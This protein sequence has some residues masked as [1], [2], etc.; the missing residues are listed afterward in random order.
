MNVCLMARFNRY[1]TCFVFVLFFFTSSGAAREAP[2][3]AVVPRPVLPEHGGA[4]AVPLVPIGLHLA[5]AAGRAVRHVALRLAVPA[6]WRRRGG[7]REHLRVG[8]THAVQ[9]RGVG[10]QHPLLP[11]P[12]G[13][14]PGGSA[15]AHLERAVRAQ[16]GAVRHAGARGAAAGRRRPARR[17]HVGRASGGLHGPHPGLSGAGGEAQDAARGLGRVLVPQGRRVVHHRYVT[18]S[19][20]TMTCQARTRHFAAN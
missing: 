2:P 4:P 1:F 11:R 3:G 19:A 7:H 6:G 15:A 5:A 12:A 18:S 10:P 13:V 20:K 17:P 14:R 9:R 16:R 8:G